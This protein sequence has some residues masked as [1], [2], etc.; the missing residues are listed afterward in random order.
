MDGK[1]VVYKITNLINDKIYIGMTGDVETRWSGNGTQY[2][3]R[4]KDKHRPFW[5][6]INKYGWEN[7]KKEIL[8]HN[9][10]F[11]Q[12]IDREIYYIAFFNATN[13]KVGYNLSVGGNGGR[14]YKVHPRGMLGKTHTVEN[15]TRQSEFMK[16]NN[17]MKEIKWG[18]THEHPRGMSGRK[19]SEKQKAIAR[20][21]KHAC[22][23]LIAVLPNGENKEFNSL[24]ECCEYIDMNPTSSVIRNLLKNGEPYKVSPN[25]KANRDK[26]L[27]LEGL[28]LKFVS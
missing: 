28:T 8:E 3:P 6:A 22:K 9:L 27:A 5:N 26:F 7:F 2:R 23:K 24:K 18:E 12:A 4:N 20:E 10:S 11:E 19:Q 25:V 21:S 15:N 16:N 17:P 14:I 13:R 1:H